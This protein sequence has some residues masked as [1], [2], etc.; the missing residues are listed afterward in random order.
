MG[1]ETISIEEFKKLDIR[2]CRVV[3]AERIP[4]KTKLLKLTVDVGPLGIRTVIAG[5]G[6]HYQPQHFIN[7]TFIILVN[8]QPKTIA[9]IKSEGMLLAADHD[10][11]PIWLTITGEA[12]PGTI[13]R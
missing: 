9:G 8:L 10:G 4:G 6:E 7:K 3:N 13:I 2:T 5:G 12:P 11:K 1:M